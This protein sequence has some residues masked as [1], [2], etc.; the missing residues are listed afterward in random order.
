MQ[1][2]RRLFCQH[3]LALGAAAVA[4]PAWA[5]NEKFPSKPIKVVVPYPAGGQTDTIARIACTN[6]AQTLGQPVLVDNRPGVGGQLGAEMVAKAPPDGY[7]LLLGLSGTMPSGSAL[8]RKLKYD[9]ADLRCVTEMVSSGAVWLVNAGLP[10]NNMRELVAYA[11]ANPDKVSVGSWGPG[12]FGH[13]SQHLL[14]AHFGAKMLH[15]PYKGEAQLI[16]DLVGGQIGL[17][18]VSAMTAKAH[19][20]SGKIRAIGFSGDARTAVFP[21]LPTVAE[22]GFKELYWMMSGPTA[23]F[24]PKATPTDV[25]AQISAAFMKAAQDP[26]FQEFAREAGAVV[27]GNSVTDAQ[28][29]YNRYY[30]VIKKVVQGTGVVID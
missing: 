27:V 10:V 14:D 18:M 20:K 8:Y 26:K 29:N 16:T 23:L 9:P 6:A 11:K 2:D 28:A 17:T 7:T 12:S 21:D 1:R 24:A 30:D 22:Q 19:L 25:V 15:V 13:A 5:Q 3:A 4:A